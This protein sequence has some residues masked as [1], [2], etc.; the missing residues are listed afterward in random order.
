MALHYYVTNS[1]MLIKCICN[2]Y[3]IWKVNIIW[4][5]YIMFLNK[6]K[7]YTQNNFNNQRGVYIY[8]LLIMLNY[9]VCLTR[10]LLRLCIIIWNLYLHKFFKFFIKIYLLHYEKFSHLTFTA[11]RCRISDHIIALAYII[12]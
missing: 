8:A 12:M 10:I 11:K 4:R 3:Y 9:K 1:N 7:Y 6:E 5:V 2:Y